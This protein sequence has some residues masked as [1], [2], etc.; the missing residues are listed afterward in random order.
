MVNTTRWYPAAQSVVCFHV[1]LM[2]SFNYSYCFFEQI[3]PLQNVFLGAGPPNQHVIRRWI[4][5]GA[6]LVR[7]QP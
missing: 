5:A 6:G 4:A 7:A 2:M 3:F 1:C